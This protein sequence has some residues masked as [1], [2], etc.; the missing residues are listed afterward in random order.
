MHF[1]GVCSM[2]ETLKA[3]IVGTWSSKST[4][5]PHYPVEVLS[6]E[7]YNKTIYI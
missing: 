4:L 7:S 1:S 3:G 5:I 6:F 2:I